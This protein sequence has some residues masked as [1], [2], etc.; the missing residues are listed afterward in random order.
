M[1]YIGAL[2]LAAGAYAEDMTN[3]GGHHMQQVRV[4]MP[5]G[6]QPTSSSAP[7]MV[8]LARPDGPVQNHSFVNRA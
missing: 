8:V 2:L 3:G 1:P 6:T 4:T 7:Q 5:P